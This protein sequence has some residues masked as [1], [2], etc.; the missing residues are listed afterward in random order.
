MLL[1]KP[2]NMEQIFH[3]NMSGALI[4]D[5]DDDFTLTLQI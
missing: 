1:T 2:W 3:L 5:V 4:R